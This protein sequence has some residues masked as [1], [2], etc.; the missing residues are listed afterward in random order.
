MVLKEHLG[1]IIVGLFVIALVFFCVRSL[2]RSK[3]KGA[4][5][6]GNCA[7]CAGCSMAG[8]CLH[9]AEK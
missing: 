6:G 9:S 3:K 5:C 8:K 1:T 4:G 7:G 2:V